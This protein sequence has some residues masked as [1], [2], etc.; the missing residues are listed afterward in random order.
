MVGAITL[1][2]L[3][4]AYYCGGY[5]GGWMDPFNGARQGL[6]VWVWVWPWSSPRSPRSP[7]SGT[8]CSPN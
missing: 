7:A 4:V 1:L 8:T 6:A 2:V 5:V 3:V